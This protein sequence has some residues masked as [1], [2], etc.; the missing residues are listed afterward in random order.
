MGRELHCK[1]VSLACV[2]SARSVWATPCFPRSRRVCPHSR[3]VCFPGLHCSGSR[4]L[5]RNCLKRALGC[6]H[7]PGLGCSGSGSRVVHKG[8][9]GW[10]WVLCPSQVRAAPATR[11]LASALAPSGRCVLSPP[12]PGRLVSWTWGGASSG[13]VVSGVPCISSGELISGCDR[14]GGCQPSRI[15]GRF[16]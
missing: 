11:C 15:P 10:A 1:Q 13:S 14:P 16:G 2:G 8:T 3:R 5:C 6:V 7:F 9:D 12:R 4:L